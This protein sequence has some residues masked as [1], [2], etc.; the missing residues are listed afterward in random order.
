M[1]FTCL[2]SLDMLLIF[3][4]S[5]KYPSSHFSSYL[6]ALVPSRVR[7]LIPSPC[8]SQTPTVYVFCQGDI[9]LSDPH[10][11]TCIV[12][13]EYVLIFIYLDTH[14]E[15]NISGPNWTVPWLLYRSHGNF[16]SFITGSAITN[17]PPVHQSLNSATCKRCID[18]YIATP[19]TITHRYNTPLSFNTNCHHSDMTH[20]LCVLNFRHIFLTLSHT[21]THTHTPAQ[22]ALSRTLSD[23][24]TAVFMKI[25][26]DTFTCTV[27]L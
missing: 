15:A 23:A 22:E 25:I 20:P 21:H 2:T 10:V 19:N 9:Q 8:R 6:H 14:F 5:G 3:G 17:Q 16:D 26:S 12:T 11:R 27:T 4:E 24:N 18:P 1:R 13:F 7:H